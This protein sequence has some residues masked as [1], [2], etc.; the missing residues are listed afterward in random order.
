MAV[1][2]LSKFQFNGEEIRAINELVYERVITSPYFGY[3]HTIVPGIEFDKEIGFITGAG[4]V[5]L[6]DPGCKSETQP[7]TINTRSLKWAPKRWEIFVEECA[8]QLENTAAQYVLRQ[9][10]N[11]YDL[12]NT[13]YMNIVAEVLES[14]IYDFLWRVVWFSD[15]EA[16]NVGTGDGVITAGTD[17]AFFNLIDGLFK[18]L[19]EQVT[20]NP[21]QGVTIAANS[22][23]TKA[24]QDSSLTPQ[25]AY[26]A[27]SNAYYALP[28]GARNSGQLQILVTRSVA[29]KY[30]QYLSS[31]GSNE[32][33]YRNVV[34][35]IARLY[36]NGVEVIPV[37]HWDMN[38][39]QYM[40][41]GATWYK[42]HRIVVV[43]KQNTMV[44][45]PTEGGFRQ[46][47]IWYER[48]DKTNYIRVNDAIDAKFGNPALIVYAS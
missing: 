47:D 19:D 39:R 18:Q 35:G 10:V 46:A 11:Y 12:T 45:M 5:G 3:I 7:W 4:L 20:L 36:F 23:N 17:V 32:L 24:L 48:K 30:E 21:A 27:I 1:I 16:A 15:T 8:T 41:L 26:E 44:G 31:V 29:N 2:D 42:P 34:D 33:Q 22:Q 38:I 25:L 6:A 14:A 13:D 28:L 40:D 9:G 43:S 37:D